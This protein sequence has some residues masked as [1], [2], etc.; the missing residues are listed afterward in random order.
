MTVCQQIFW[1]KFVISDKI[2]VD[3][4]EERCS[5]LGGW[6][7][8]VLSFIALWWGHGPVTYLSH[9]PWPAPALRQDYHPIIHSILY[10]ITVSHLFC[11]SVS[12]SQ[13]L[14]SA[15]DLSNEMIAQYDRMSR[16][17]WCRILVSKSQCCYVKFPEHSSHT[18]KTFNVLRTLSPN[19][20]GSCGEP[21][22]SFTN[23]SRRI[24]N[25][26]LQVKVNSDNNDGIR[27]RD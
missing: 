18:R 7:W 12:V 3:W 19:A 21:E 25:L 15:P 17:C 16:G 10:Q 1:W 2:L 22:R 23:L 9:P 8:S 14:F 6:K 13:S 27:R 26:R 11:L 4:Y 20:W 24:N 5:C